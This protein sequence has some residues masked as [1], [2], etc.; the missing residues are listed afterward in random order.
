VIAAIITESYHPS[1]CFA[2]SMSISFVIVYF[3]LRLNPNAENANFGEAGAHENDEV[4]IQPAHEEENK[5]LCLEISRY[6]SEIKQAFKEP[7]FYSIILYL[8]LTAALVP[9]FGTFSYYF[10]MDVVHVSQFAYS[11]LGL[12]GYLCLMGGTWLYQRVF[13]FYE[14][15]TLVLMEAAF[16]VLMAPF[17]FMFVFRKNTKYGIPDLPLLI[18]TETVTDTLSMAL[19]FLP[20]SVLFAKICPKNIEATCFAILAGVSNFRGT[21]RGWLG[22]L[23]NEMFVGVKKDDLRHYWVLTV[24]AFVCGFL[25]LMFLWLLPTKSQV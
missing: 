10:M 17:L 2:I 1:Y 25:P 7:I 20:M 21:A 4:E 11:M 22:S 8:C 13:K 15:R 19:I 16:S 12:V 23:V 6:F 5:S 14:L 3:T 9:S 24:I 18:F